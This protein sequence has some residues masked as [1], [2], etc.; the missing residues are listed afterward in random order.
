MV[1]MKRGRVWKVNKDRIAALKAEDVLE[2]DA[3]A[4]RSQAQAEGMDC[5]GVVR[6]SKEGGEGR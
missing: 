5:A 2:A 6:G 3:T 1:H 4:N